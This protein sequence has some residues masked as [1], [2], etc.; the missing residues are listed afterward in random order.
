MDKQLDHAHNRFTKKQFAI[1]II[2]HNIF[3]PLNVGS[4]FRTCDAFGVR[5]LYLS[6]ITPHP[7]NQKIRKTSR[8]TETQ[9]VWQYRQDVHQT[10]DDLKQDGCNIIALEITEHSQ[11]LSTFTP[12]SAQP[13]AILIGNE[14]QGIADDLLQKADD[15]LHIEMY[16]TNSSMNVVQ[17]TSVCLYHFC[18]SM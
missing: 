6:G 7:P 9:V 4:L 5:Q 17:A 3:S 8:S 12:H 15:I 16:G 1:D 11:S 13:Y 10:I 2:A 18:K 14:N